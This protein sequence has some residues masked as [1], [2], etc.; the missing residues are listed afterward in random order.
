MVHKVNDIIEILENKINQ[1]E[2]Y[3]QQMKNENRKTTRQR[4]SE[5]VDF[6][7]HYIQL[8]AGKKKMNKLK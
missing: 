3:K 1:I 2:E 6:A 7:T 8:D 4:Y 5:E